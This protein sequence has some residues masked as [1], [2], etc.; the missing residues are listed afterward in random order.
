M[1]DGDRPAHTEAPQGVDQG[2]GPEP[3]VGPQAQRGG[4]A[5][6]ADTGDELF[7][8]ALGAPL[9]GTFAQPGV[10]HL[11]GLRDGGQQRVVAQ[12][13]GVAVGGALLVVAVDLADRGVHVD[14]QR[15][16]GGPRPSCQARPI[17]SAITASSWRTCPKVK[18]RRNVPS[19]EGAIT[20]NGST[21]RVAPAR[22]TSA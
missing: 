18:A 11:A 21:A 22:S 6:P 8:E 19:V 20:R 4:G 5:G 10:E 2:M 12:G 14:G 7:D 17:V 3:R 1:R 13:A 9:A 15:L 16:F